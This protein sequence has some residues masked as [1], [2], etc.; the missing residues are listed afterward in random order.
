MRIMLDLRE[1]ASPEEAHRRLAHALSFPD[2]YGGNLD[3][4]YDV[5]TAWGRPLVLSLRLPRSGDMAA[6]GQR[7]WRVFR[8]AAAVN[9]NLTIK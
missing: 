1:I 2:Y 3:A 9:P 4:L 7:M 6:Y 5:L 8:D